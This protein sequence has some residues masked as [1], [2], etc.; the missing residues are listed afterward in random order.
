MIKIT[1]PD[2]SVREYA[3]GVTGMQV[4]ESISP[5]LAQE[6]I[7][8]K[9]NGEVVE[10]NR[11]IQSD[12]TLQLLKWEDEEGKHAFWHTSAH[13]MAEALQELYP[14]IQFGIGPA[15]ENGF[16]YDVDPGTAVIKEGDFAAIEAKFAEIVSRKADLIREDI[17]KADALSMFGDKGQTYKQ[18]L[19]NDLQDGHITI[20]RQ[21]NFVDLCKGPHLANTGIIKAFKVISVAGAYWRG[22]EKRPQLTRL[23]GISFPKKKM[24]DDYLLLLEEAKK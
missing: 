23:Y 10:V 19:I 11:P 13:V 1:F 12:A 15:I 21:G 20:Y 24:L 18:E 9:V 14:G 6:V 7:A 8:A 5:R 3:A 2:G 4:A 22:D 16:Y 17:S